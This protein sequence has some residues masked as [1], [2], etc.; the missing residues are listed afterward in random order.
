MSQGFS[1]LGMH[2]GN[3]SRLS[4]AK[5][6]SISPENSPA[7]R[8]GAGWRAGNRRDPR[9][10]SGAGLEDL[11]LDTR[12]R[13]ARRFASRTSKGLARSSR[14]GSRPPMCLARPH[15]AHLLGRSGATVGRG[16]AGRFLRLRM[17]P[18][19]ARSTRSPCASIRGRRSTAIGKCRSAS[20]P[21]SPS[22][23][24]IPT[25]EAIIYCQINY[26]LTDVPEDA[27][28]F[29]AQFRRINPLPYKEDYTVLDGVRGVGIT[30]ELTWPGASTTPA[31]GA[32]ARSSSFSTATRV[33]DHLRHRRRGLFLRRL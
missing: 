27:A 18:L 20:A 19:C 4:A 17:G 23:T 21:G 24:A 32:R 3:L 13:R 16:A 31:G 5:S 9:A 10:R 15:P 8:A 6:R 26:T 14:C 12:R 33:S 22:R 11:A 25:S 2:L 30:S 1:G 29:H 28:Y 7:R